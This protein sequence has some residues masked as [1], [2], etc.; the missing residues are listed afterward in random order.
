[1]RRWSANDSDILLTMSYLAEIYERVG[2][3]E[4]AEELYNMREPEVRPWRGA[5]GYTQIHER[6]R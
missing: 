2:Q 3:M 4:E 6:P 5:P 1:M